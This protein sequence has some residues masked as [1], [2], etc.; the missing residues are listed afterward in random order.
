M[1]EQFGLGDAPFVLYA[2]TLEPRKN[3]RRLVE[4]FAGVARDARLADH[5]LV[6]A[7]GHWGEHDRELRDL[8]EALGRRPRWC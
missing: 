8:A 3:L 1:R 4:A 6:L 7:G 5:R 2:G